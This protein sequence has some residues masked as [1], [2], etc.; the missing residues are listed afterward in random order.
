MGRLEAFMYVD[1][2]DEQWWAELSEVLALEVAR[3]K[4][5]LRDE[6][7]PGGSLLTLDA[8]NPGM[9]RRVQNAVVVGSRTLKAMTDLQAQVNENNTRYKDLVT[10]KVRRIAFDQGVYDRLVSG[11]T[12][13]VSPSRSI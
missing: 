2:V 8:T 13:N 6:I 10:R 12:Q 3:F 9:R 5:R 11:P 7:G 4:L 1:T